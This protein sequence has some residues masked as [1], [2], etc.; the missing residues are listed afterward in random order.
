MRRKILYIIGALI[1]AGGLI[2]G[3]II[4]AQLKLSDL[5]GAT[6]KEQLLVKNEEGEYESPFV[7]VAERVMP[8]VV[9][10]STER[11]VKVKE[12]PFPFQ[13][14]GPFDE[15]FKKF[16]EEPFKNMPREYHSRSLGSGFIFKKDGNKYYILT[17]YHVI[18]NADKII[19]RLSDKTEIK[20]KEVKIIG[21]D[22]NTDIA[23][24]MIKSDKE[25]PVLKLGD[26]DRIKVGDW[27][28]AVGNPFGLDRTVTVGVISAKGR[29][30][31]YLPEG[32][33]YENFIQTDAAINPGNSGGPLVNLKGEVIGI[34]T[35]ITSPS[36]GFV[37]IGFAIPVNTAKYVSEQLIEKGR[38]VR[39][40]L[41]VYPQELTADLAKAYGLEKPEGVLIRQVKEGSPA[42]KAGLKDGDVI[43]KFNGKPVKDLESFRLMVAKTP[44]GTVV[45]VV[46]IRENGVK[47]T[48]R[49]KLGEYPEDQTAARGEEEEEKSYS[50]EGKGSWAG[51]KVMDLK[52]E[53]AKIYYKGKEKEGVVIYEIE[54]GSP[55]DDARLKRGDVIKKIGGI[56]IK[57]IKDFEKAAQKFKDSEKPVLLKIIRDGF[58]YY[59]AIE[60]K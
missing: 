40:Y 31:I 32:P 18:K 1:F 11:I 21:K 19:I 35:A 30:G 51:M 14:E 56:E 9:N 4:T 8:A 16:F 36:G 41:G 20:G 54:A 42:D 24:L 39:G 34:N 53:E 52:S 60:P 28:I 33:I 47:K 38:V 55:A 17:N 7:K 13:F 10:I 29:S 23:V 22:K 44:P 49:V 15:F 27:A 45:D 57:G 3:V 12:E 58:P 50:E 46:V 48:L 25:L 43:I 6:S 59:L 26:S 2:S 37:G 5:N